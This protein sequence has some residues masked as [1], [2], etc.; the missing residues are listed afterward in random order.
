MESNCWLRKQR[1][2][3]ANGVVLRVPTI[4]EVLDIEQLYYSTASTLTA[5][6]YQFMVQ[7]DDMG[8]DYTTITEFQFFQMMFL[9][10][11]KQETINKLLEEQG[12]YDQITPSAFN[13]IFE[14]LELVGF[15]IY[16]NPETQETCLLN[17]ITNVEINEFVY[18]QLV[19]AMRK[20]NNFEHVKDKPGNES[21]KKYLMEKERRRLK[22][23]SKKPYEPYLEKLVV[24]MVNMP[25]FKYNYEQTFGMSLYVFNES[26]AQVQHKV[27]FDKTM[28]GVSIG[29]ADTKKMT[30]KSILSWIRLGS[31]ENKN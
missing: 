3:I 6:P 19:K 15:D 29:F 11:V 24:S 9:S 18:Y 26:L 31:S 7:L 2:P 5:V 23:E 12:M 17:S 10:Y 22:R 16:V 25:E 4:E 28:I 30:D 21:A 14:D 20:L 8:V 1:I 27:T 13:V